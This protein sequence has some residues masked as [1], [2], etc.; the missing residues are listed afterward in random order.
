MGD[1]STTPPFPEVGTGPL[2]TRG[3]GTR[4]T[5]TCEVERLGVE[6]SGKSRNQDTVMCPYP[7]DLH[8]TKNSTTD[9]KSL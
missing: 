6:T 4:V 7:K 9:E 1:C 8:L 3:T 5:G 2:V